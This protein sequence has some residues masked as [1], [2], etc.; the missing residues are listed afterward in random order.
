MSNGPAP[1][2]NPAYSL[3]E[4]CATAIQTEGFV[5][6]YDRITGSHFGS[7]AKRSPLDAMIDQATG[8]ETEEA[9]KF[10][11][12]VAETVWSR[13]PAEPEAMNAEEK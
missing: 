5:E 8:R 2:F 9:A 4:C 3:E 7:L 6:N 11:A 13:L 12:F 1:D 10:C